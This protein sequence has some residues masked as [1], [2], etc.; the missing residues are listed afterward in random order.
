MSVDPDTFRSILGRFATGVTVITAADT[1]RGDFGITVTAFASLSLG[2]PLVLV[3]IDHQ[4]SI[5][6]VMVTASHFVVN[7]LAAEQ[8]AIARR[9]SAPDDEQRFQGL[10][11]SRG[12]TGA[13]VLDDVLAY[14]E[15][16]LVQATEGG[17]HTIFA[18]AVEVAK[19]RSGRPLLYYRGGYAQLER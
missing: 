14:L 11:Y 18:G 15:C 1:A 8:E 4:A 6:P 10:G 9:F 5:H 17:D 19:S 13:A 2:P 12:A 3:C 16:R 7:V